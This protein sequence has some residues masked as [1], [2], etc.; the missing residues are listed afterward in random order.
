M[1]LSY[2]GQKSIGLRMLKLI[3]TSYLYIKFYLKVAR[4]YAVIMNLVGWQQNIEHLLTYFGKMNQMF[5]P[6]NALLVALP[7]VK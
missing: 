7:I 2:E 4:L 5:H 6:E 1:V 3:Y